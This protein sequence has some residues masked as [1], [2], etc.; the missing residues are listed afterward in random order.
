[1]KALLLDDEILVLNNLKFL[2]K[3]FSQ[4]DIVYESTSAAE[5]VSWIKENLSLIHI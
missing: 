4:I 2:L 3:N 5:V 1:M